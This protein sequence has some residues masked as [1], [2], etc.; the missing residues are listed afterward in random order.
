MIID[1]HTHVLP[2]FFAQNI[3]SLRRTDAT[4][5][6]L[7][8]GTQKIASSDDLIVAMNEDGIDLAVA[9]GYGWCDFDLARISNDYLLEAGK[10]YP[11]KVIPFCSVHPDWGN[12]ALEELERC[13]AQGARGI[14]ELHP[15]SQEIDLETNPNL[16]AIM[17]FARAHH[18]PLMIHSSEP[19]GH[20]YPG[21][22]KTRPEAL[23]AFAC[24]YPENI[25]VCAHWGGGLPFYKLMP[26]VK[27]DLANVFFDSAASPYLYEET[28]FSHGVRAAGERHV[29]FASDFPLV[30]PKRVLDQ[31]YSAFKAS[32]MEKSLDAILF[33]NAQ[34]LL[35]L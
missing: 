15:T 24:R 23:W 3:E 27:A 26:E 10:C 9:V 31:V 6:S 20:N 21:K 32:G 34:N 13:V 17:E 4:F 25:I 19:V 11:N 33:R 29:L 2:P 12:L 30:R 28:I 1:F 5:A 18:L 8:D 35:G 14:G 7:F 22:G 16:D